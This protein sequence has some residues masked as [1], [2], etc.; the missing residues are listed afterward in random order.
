MTTACT[1]TIWRLACAIRVSVFVR[2]VRRL[3]QVGRIAGAF[4]FFFFSVNCERVGSPRFYVE[5]HGYWET[6]IEKCGPYGRE[7]TG[8]SR[9][10]R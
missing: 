10:P 2:V 4:F 9:L 8:S 7:S 1:S 3:T 5:P 6:P